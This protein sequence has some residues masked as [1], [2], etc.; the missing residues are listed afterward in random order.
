VKDFST[1]VLH[2]L[3]GRIYTYESKEIFIDIGTIK[4]YKKASNFA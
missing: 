4:S 1:E 3:V 2:Q